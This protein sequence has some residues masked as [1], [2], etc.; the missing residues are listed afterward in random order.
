MNT[1][2]YIRIVEDS[3]V[4][5]EMLGTVMQFERIRY[6]TTSD[7]FELLLTP[8]P[9]EGVTAVLCDLDLG[10]KKING[11][12]ILGYLAQHHPHIKR[13]VLSATAEITSE[14][15]KS[16]AHATLTKPADLAG[17]IEALK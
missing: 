5:A 13:V 9:W 3:Y 7:N 10:N 14:K 16:L 1:E 15:I 17:I 4:L 12:Q 6:S 11:E 2:P 8:D